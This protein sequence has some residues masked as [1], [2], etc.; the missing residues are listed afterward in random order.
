[1]TFIKGKRFFSKQWSNTF[2]KSKL[3]Q[4]SLF[5]KFIFLLRTLGVGRA[6]FKGS[7]PALQIQANPPFYTPISSQAP[8]LSSSATMHSNHVRLSL[9]SGSLSLL[10]SQ[11]ESPF[12]FLFT[13]LSFT[14]PSNFR[15]PSLV[16][17][18][19]PTHTSLHA[20]PGVSDSLCVPVTPD[21]W[22]SRT[23]VIPPSTSPD[24]L[25]VSN[26]HRAWPPVG[27]SK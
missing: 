4:S 7:I 9:T 3:K 12:P 16:P 15:Q 13:W 21:M 19:T 18:G 22:H 17:P 26:K 6:V 27:I 20:P 11:L 1:M 2:E 5:S 25:S 10:F 24:S 8:L 23:A 14:H